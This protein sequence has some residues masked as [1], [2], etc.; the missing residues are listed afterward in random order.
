MRDFTN[1][2]DQGIFVPGRHEGV[3]T[4]NGLKIGFEVCLDHSLG[5]LKNHLLKA[6]LDFHIIASAEVNNN[7]SEICVAE[8]GYLLHA[9]ANDKFSKVMRKLPMKERKANPSPLRTQKVK[10]QKPDRIDVTTYEVGDSSPAM[11]VGGDILD[12]ENIDNAMF[13]V[14]KPLE[15]V[16]VDKGLLKF[17]LLEN[18]K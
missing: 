7:P 5:T 15:T 10:Q 2:S 17:Y 11:A 3:T 12:I 16:E 18:V 4:I 1:D 6:D 14:L 13:Q 9:S 8:G